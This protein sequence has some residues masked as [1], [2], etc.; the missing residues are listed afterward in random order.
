MAFNSAIFVLA[1]LPVC[2]IGYYGLSKLSGKNAKFFLILASFAFYAWSSLE[3]VPLLAASM[4]ANYLIADRIQTCLAKGHARSAAAWCRFGVLANLGL[5]VY[6]KYT[7]FLI[8]NTNF[9]FGTNVPIQYIILPLGI[10]FYSF[11]R[12]AYLV[13][14]ARGEIPRSDPLGFSLFAVFFPQLISGPIVRYNEIHPQFQ[15]QPAILGSNYNLLVG[16][17][18]FIIGMAKKTAIADPTGSITNE[19]FDAASRGVSFDLVN[20]WLAALSFTVQLYF[21]FSGYSDMAI[22]L[23]RMFGV[24]LPPNFHSPL[25]AASIIDYWRRWHMTL[26]R[27]MASYFYQP[28]SLAFTRKAADYG[29]GRWSNFMVSAAAPAFITFLVM[30][31]W[32][33]AGWTYV[34]FGVMHAV[35]VCINEAWREFQRH[36][37]RRLKRTTSRRNIPSQVLGHVITVG[38]VLLANVMFR[39]DRV[40]TAL[41]I[42]KGMFGLSHTRDVSMLLITKPWILIFLVLGILVIALMPNTQQIMRAYRPVLYWP[43][44]RNVAPSLIHWRWRPNALG[45]A[46]AGLLSTIVIVFNLMWMSHGPAQFIYFKF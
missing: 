21:D 35:F 11:Q 45:V 14:C 27:F 16:A 1:F 23:A 46:L 10:S 33:G 41:L 36:R 2:L 18:I 22:G 43:Q 24:V 6:F 32:H 8:D 37:R 20:G 29:L 28:L 25:R 12:I 30:G 5:L 38:C 7:N 26:T 4:A 31:I 42:Y 44:W 40:T 15:K 17:V 19:L 34:W 3:Y 39:A 13:D 9:A